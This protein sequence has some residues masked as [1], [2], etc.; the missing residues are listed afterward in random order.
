MAKKKTE[1]KPSNIREAI[2]LAR[3]LKSERADFLFGLLIIAFAV[4]TLI[5]M[6]SYMKTGAADQ[7]ILEN[8][9]PG[10][11][12]NTDKIRQLRKFLRR[13]II[14]FLHNELF[15]IC[16]ISHTLLSYSCGH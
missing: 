16:S 4:Y 10:E 15:R 13:S 1:R 2:G 11:W 5:A 14:L 7:S 6:F 9:R 12:I 3:F 8:L